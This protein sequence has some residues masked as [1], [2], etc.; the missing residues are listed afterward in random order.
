[1]AALH[2]ASHS[3]PLRARRSDRAGRWTSQPNSASLIGGAMLVEAKLGMSVKV[4]PP[5][6]HLAVKQIDEVWDLHGDR[7]T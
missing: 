2:A 4:V 3:Q 7:C 1:M 5:G 6:G